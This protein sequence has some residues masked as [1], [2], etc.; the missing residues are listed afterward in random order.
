MSGR[1]KLITGIIILIILAGVAVTYTV[2]MDFVP[3]NESGVMGNNAGNL[4][5]GGFFC[6]HDGRVYFANVYE[7]RSLYSMKPD[8]T[9]VKR[10]GTLGVNNI[11]AGGHFLYFF[12]DSTQYKSGNKGLGY[13]GNTYG[14]YRYNLR[15]NKMASLERVRVKSMQLCGSYIYYS[16]DSDTQSGLHKCKI[17]GKERHLISDNYITPASYDGNY[18]YFAGNPGNA[19]LYSMNT[20]IGDTSARVMEGNISSPVYIDGIIY[21]IDNAAGYKL[22]RYNRATGAKEIVCEERVD[23]FNTNG[24]YI[25]YCV[26]ADGSPALKRMNM[27]G[28]NV[29]VIAD[30]AYNSINYTSQFLYFAPFD[31][32]G[33]VS[34]MY[35]I[36]VGGTGPMTR[37]DPAV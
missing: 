29:T 14:L 24:R 21:Y 3:M 16:G 35:H 26:S 8:E 6:E 9:D 10:L 17:N 31:K 19:S 20:A 32:S 13:V 28:S 11:C 4:V 15:G 12:M 37:F 30:G 34:Y 18:I 36:P 23:L 7:S 22:C 1:A 33:T 25:W 2:I 27:D 5:N